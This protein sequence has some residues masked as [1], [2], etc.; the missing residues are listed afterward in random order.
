[1]KRVTTIFTMILAGMCALMTT[2]C[3]SSN[4]MIYANSHDGFLN[5][6]EEPSAKSPILGVIYNGAAGAEHLG[7]VD[8]DWIKVNKGGIE[9]YVHRNYVQKVPAAPVTIETEALVG[10]WTCSVGKG[11]NTTAILFFKDGTYAEADNASLVKTIGQWTMGEGKIQLKQTYDMVKKKRARAKT[12]LLV[13][14]RD[15]IRHLLNEEREPEDLRGELYARPKSKANKGG[16]DE[17][18]YGW[19]QAQYDQV[20]AAITPYI[21]K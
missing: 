1:M 21:K 11:D 10:V 9:G 19:P 16:E 12:T 4:E 6:R 5:I 17:R 14:R 8:G 18:E 15:N 7:V 2:G 3:K 20:K 13:V